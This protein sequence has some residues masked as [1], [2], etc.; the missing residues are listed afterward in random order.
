MPIYILPDAKSVSLAAADLVA[1]LVRRKPD[2]VVGLAAGATPEATYAELVRRHREEG[3]DFRQTR[4][5]GLDEYLGLSADHPASCAGTL[6]RCLLD[7]VN[8][9]ADNIH[10]FD[11][12][13]QGD[14]AAYCARHEQTIKDA[15]GI[16]VQILGLGVNGHIGFNEPGASLKGRAHVL[17]LR[18]S[19]LATNGPIFAKLGEEIPKTAVTIGIGTILEARRVL[20]LVTGAKKAAAAAKALEGPVTAMLPAS[21]LQMHP[22]AVWMLDEAAGADLAL[23]DDYKAEAAALSRLG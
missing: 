1:D 7:R 16:D 8:V 21:A 11:G 13:F 5:V 23:K 2:A 14:L 20:M 10:L 12:R 17:A 18:S 6:R 22:D 19:T 3:L 9:S 4:F 15:G